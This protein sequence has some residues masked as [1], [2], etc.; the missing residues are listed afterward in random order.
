MFR[1]SIKTLLF[2]LV[3]LFGASL[4]LSAQDEPSSIPTTPNA[5]TAPVANRKAT[6]AEWEAAKAGIDY[7]G[8]KKEKPKKTSYSMPKLPDFLGG[9]GQLGQIA[10]ICLVIAL[11]AGL[12]YVLI[13]Q[14][15]FLKNSAVAP[16]KA[17]FDLADIEN[18]LHETD[19]DRY[20]RTAITNNDYRLAV[21]LYYLNV[22]KQYSLHEVI[23]WK[24]DKTNGE[25]LTEVRRKNDPTYPDFRTVTL[26]FERV[27]YGEKVINERD[28]TAIQ[29]VF[30]RLLGALT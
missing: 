9:L 28:Y 17:D 19:L 25:Y 15:L 20:L 4:N 13:G 18:N 27:W 26:L 7:S 2:C 29:P 22:L 21:R 3:C 11:V 24:K 23:I 12:F 16:P 8:L 10:L 6:Q 5:T 1:N 30:Q 14:G